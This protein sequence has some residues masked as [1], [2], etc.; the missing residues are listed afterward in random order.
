MM[1]IYR[2]ATTIAAPLMPWWL[3]R[4]RAQGKEDPQRM[5]ERLG[6]ASLT[7][8]KGRVFWIHAASVGEANAALPLIE[9]L[10]TR[11]PHVQ[12]LLT[13]GT[14]TSARLMEKRLPPGVLHQFAPIDTPAAAARFIA[15][16][17]PELGIWVESELWPNLV[18]EVRASG[19]VLA[20]VNARMSARSAQRWRFA[21]GLIRRM[22]ACFSFIAAQSEGDAARFRT[23]AVHTAVLGN[24]KYDAPPLVCD[25]NE[26]AALRESIGVRPVW[27]VASTHPGEE[28]LIAAAHAKLK[29][30][31]TDILTLIVPRHPVRGPQVAAA[32]GGFSVARRAGGEHLSKDTELYIADTLGELGLFYRVCPLVLMGG[33]LVEHGGQNP[34]E[35]ARLGCAVLAGP[36]M[37]N[38]L[39]MVRAMQD[40][41]AVERIETGD[42]AHAVARLLAAPQ[43]I[44]QRGARA[45]QWAEGQGGATARIAEALAMLVNRE[46]AHAA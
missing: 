43:E 3:A 24:M 23:W 16:W 31:Y 12:L 9:T 7:R 28:E 2:A 13:T 25:E 18:L 17:Q 37:E 30:H 4:R 14:V 34:F 19:C 41:A 15:H 39:E 21:P 44:A 46:A 29:M 45:K 42:I 8:P 36:H 26:L 22:L 6:Y 40:A 35:A 5:R 33:S 20:L 27:L 11:Y 38:F 32:L 1:A 10:R